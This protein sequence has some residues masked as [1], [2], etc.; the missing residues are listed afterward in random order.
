[1][2]DHCSRSRVVRS[3]VDIAVADGP[4]QDLTFDSTGSRYSVSEAQAVIST[5]RSDLKSILGTAE[6]MNPAACLVM[7]ITYCEAQRVRIAAALRDLLESDDIS[8]QLVGVPS[9]QIYRPQHQAC[10]W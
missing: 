9:V 1:M 5:M 2:P 6:V 4:Y 3:K 10:D 8:S 7:V